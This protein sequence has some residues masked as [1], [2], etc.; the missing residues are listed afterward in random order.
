MDAMVL[1]LTDLRALVTAASDDDILHD[2]RCASWRV[3]ELIG[4]CEGMLVSLVSE[5][6][7]PH[8]GPPEIDRFDVYR[9][10]SWVPGTDTRPATDKRIHDRVVA[11]T[12]GR[13]PAQL[14]T[15]LQF[16]VD[17]VIRALPQIPGDRVVIRPPSYPRMTYE[18]LVAS[19]LLEIGIHTADIAGALGK[20]EDLAPSAA[21][22][23]VAIIDTLLGEPRPD[24]LEWDAIRYILCATGRGELTPS[25]R[26]VLGPRA[27]S[28]PL[29][30]FALE[31]PPPRRSG[32]QFHD[33][34][35]GG[36]PR[37]ERPSRQK[38]ER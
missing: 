8:Y 33:L 2:T 29:P 7:Q 16:V 26:D 30:F 22:I 21:D 37:S 20:P 24:E 11:Y 15:S 31:D 9:R 10:M 23:V 3:A 34:E 28:F 35:V 27:A 25:E 18:E 36:H 1:Q 6:A 12:S 5:S 13:R 19:R 4:H 32:D 14:R 38:V 17:G